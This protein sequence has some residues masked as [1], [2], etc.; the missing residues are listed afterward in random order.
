MTEH[1]KR[2]ALGASITL[3]EHVRGLL[4]RDADALRRDGLV[5]EASEVSELAHLAELRIEAQHNIR[6][7]FTQAPT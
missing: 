7:P 4:I 3:L 5:S 2:A 6:D 1:R